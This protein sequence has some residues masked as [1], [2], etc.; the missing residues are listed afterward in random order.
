LEGNQDAGMRPLFSL[1]TVNPNEAFHAGQIADVTG[2]GNT[3]VL[4]DLRTDH[5]TDR[6]Y[7][8]I[9]FQVRGATGTAAHLD[10]VINPNLDWRHSDVGQELIAYAQAQIEPVNPHP[11]LPEV[12][13]ANHPLIGIIDTG[14]STNNPDI[15]YSHIILGHDYID[16]DSN[17]LLP[18]GVGNEHGTHILGIIGATQNN[19]VGIDGINDDAPI[20]VSRAVGSGHW[21]DSLVEFV[22]AAKASHQPNAVVNLS[23]DLTQINHD[24]SITTRYEFTP[25]ER[26]AIEYARQNHVLIVAAAG[27]DGGVMSVLG[28]ASQEFDNII[29]VGA[30]DGLER[31]E[32]SSYGSGLDILAPGGTSENPILSAVGDGVGTMAGTSVAAA[33]V[34]GAISQVW[35]A[36]PDLSYRQVIEIL[37]STATDLD[38]PGWDA[39][40]GSGLLNLVAAVSV[41]RTV[42]PEDFIPLPWITPETWS[43]AGVVT[44]EERAASGGNSIATAPTYTS[45]QISDQ[46]TVSS[47]QPEKY[48]RFIVNEPGYMH[49]TTTRIN[50]SQNLPNVSV[51]KADGSPANYQFLSGVQQGGA[52]GQVSIGAD[53][54]VG[55]GASPTSSEGR[56]FFDPGT[57]Y[58]KVDSGLISG[59]KNYDLTTEFIPDRP[60]NFAGA[61]QFITP[62]PNKYWDV[63]SGT[64]APQLSTSGILNTDGTPSERTARYGLEVNEPGKLTIN[65]QSGQGVIELYAR[66]FIGSSDR[67]EDITRELIDD[68]GNKTIELNVN[69]GKYQLLLNSDWDNLPE[70]PFTLNATF[71]PNDA[72]GSIQTA[73]EL[74]KPISDYK[75]YSD[76]IGGSDKKD[77][78]RFELDRDSWLSLKL[79]GKNGDADLNILDA[80]GKIVYQSRSIGHNLVYEEL[81]A[82]TYYV[83]VF[84]ANSYD[85]TAYDLKIAADPV[86][87]S[88]QSSSSGSS[89]VSIGATPVSNTGS[90]SVSI[91][92]TPLSNSSGSAT[93]IQDSDGSLLTAQ[94]VNNQWGGTSL[95]H[96]ITGSVSGFDKYDY[97]RFEVSEPSIVTAK[98]TSLIGD[99]NLLIIQDSNNNGIDDYGDWSYGPVKSPS[100]VQLNP[101][102]YYI[103]VDQLGSNVQND[104][105]LNLSTK[106]IN[107]NANTSVSSSGS[108]SSSV[109]VGGN[110]PSQTVAPLPGQGGVPANAGNLVN[111]SSSGGVTTYYYSNG[112]LSVQ[113]SGYQTWYHSGSGTSSTIFNTTPIPVSADYAGN[114]SS[115]ARNIGLLLGSVSPISDFVGSVDPID[116]YRF[117]LDRRSNFNLLLN[118]L[119]GDADVRLIR[120]ENNNGQVD[121]GDKLAGLSQNNSNLPESIAT[122]LEPGNYFVKIESKVSDTNY[123]LNLSA[124]QTNSSVNSSV[125]I[126]SG[127]SSGGTTQS[128]P[129]NTTNNLTIYPANHKGLVTPSI[130]VQWRNSP[131]VNDRNPNNATAYGSWLSFDGWTYGESINDYQTGVQDNIWWRIAGTNYWVPSAYIANEQPITNNTSNSGSTNP[132]NNYVGGTTSATFQ[133][134]SNNQVQYNT[135]V[136]IGDGE[137]TLPYISIDRIYDAIDADTKVISGGKIIVSG[138]S[139]TQDM[140]FYIGDTKVGGNLDYLNDGTF[141]ARLNIPS[142]IQLGNYQVK[143]VAR[144]QLG[145]TN[146][147]YSNSWI[148][149]VATNVVP[150]K[151]DRDPAFIGTTNGGENY[152]GSIERF[153]GGYIENRDTWIVIHGMDSS[154]D[155]IKNL[156]EAIEGYKE[157]DQILTLDWRDAAKSNQFI[158]P[159][160]GIGASFIEA[161][162]T[163][164]AKNLTGWGINGV[165][166]INLVG[167]SLGAYVAAEIA[168]RIPGGVNRII[169][170]DPAKELWG[171]Y[172]S[173]SVNFS[174]N[175]QFSWGFYGSSLGSSPRTV[176][177]DESFSMGFGTNWGVGNHGYVKDVFAYMVNQSYTNFNN[178]VSK[179]FDINN[180]T[181]SVPRPWKFNE[182]NDF[183]GNLVWNREYEGRIEARDENGGLPGENWS[184]LKFTYFD[185]SSGKVENPKYNWP[186][187]VL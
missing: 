53:G 170:L 148:N 40:T 85:N 184:Q 56:A 111:I 153:G 17:P 182:F 149:V 50:N 178:Q 113:P 127:T 18:S 144:N 92:T 57:Y 47:T 107:S 95:N 106:P 31:A 93:N 69:K 100:P 59:A 58:L 103:R 177:A 181:W 64:I 152:Y 110:S 12:P 41:A 35:A 117:N 24:G 102:T 166:N 143:I 46:D 126:G 89:S 154:P 97:Y 94:S 15:N 10:D 108:S 175:S 150:T 135:Q 6:D 134:P 180:M 83:Q 75:I 129:V 131:K 80:S 21:S 151:V 36:N 162:A 115:D 48:Y 169:A 186:W 90:S 163:M 157:G 104:Y 105:S 77:F 22:D 91:G 130:G 173:E 42:V 138:S 125:S 30:A 16:G 20:W 73:K 7:N 45:P 96:T 87:S 8:D 43:G 63:F 38:A 109:S 159:L 172:D 174:N 82:G 51:I 71:S 132:I 23:L 156:A 49:W 37:K 39:E 78:Y 122:T 121:S 86:N 25:L 187:W 67:Y 3:F 29:T 168:E 119:T 1:H 81:K 142:D 146:N 118:E 65:V 62:S 33:E 147:F 133:E 68:T 145:L 112:Y 136:V 55:L 14:F 76:S 114:T 34:T 120:D 9:I 137:I 79:I 72:D 161:T 44:P 141:T 74:G 167:H 155:G 101:G 116:F 160:P 60:S 139:N 165:N 70:H 99:A 66:K 185:N 2:D 5:W 28:Q 13:I 4:E 179:F 171:G 158:V 84:P 19:G 128:S 183:G 61:Y 98:L 124:Q 140:E 176:T 123:K 52:F 54:S 27:N 164:V 32:Y 11:T 26:A 88:S